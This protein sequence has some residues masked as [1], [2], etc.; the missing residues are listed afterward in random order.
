MI[1]YAFTSPALIAQAM[2]HSSYVNEAAEDAALANERLEFFGDAV[3]GMVITERLYHAF[4]GFS[5]GKL[6]I[7]KSRLV[8]GSRLALGARTLGLGEFI[9]LGKGEERLGGRDKDSILSSVFEALV[10][11][12]YLDGGLDQARRFIEKVFEG[13]FKA[14]GAGEQLD[15]KSRLQKFAQKKYGM[16]PSYAVTAETGPDHRKVFRVEVRVGEFL[17]ASASGK[18]KKEAEQEAARQLLG[19]AEKL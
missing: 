13:E 7:I 15:Y 4:P 14:A 16:I 11:A 3:V 5:E 8:S 6:S 12:I 10:A 2:K 9:L 1:G 17:A 19:M 18:S